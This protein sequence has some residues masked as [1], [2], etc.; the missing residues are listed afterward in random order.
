M[1]RSEA[2]DIIDGKQVPQRVL[3]EDTLIDHVH[4]G[5]VI[6]E[7]GTLILKGTIHGTLSIQ[8]GAEAIIF[9]KQHGTVSIRGG[10]EVT[11]HGKISGTVSLSR[12][13]KLNIEEGGVV[14]GTLSNNGLVI[15]RGVFGGANSGNGDF[16]I[17]GNGFVKSPEIRDGIHYYN[18]D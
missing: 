15:L 13:S 12:D 7:S 17:E 8:P 11:V 6:V 14:A 4:R 18:W 16:L 10:A 5:T 2:F 1:E 3:H 9:G